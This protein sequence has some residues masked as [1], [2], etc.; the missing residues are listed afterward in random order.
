MILFVDQ[1]SGIL[2]LSAA[3]VAAFGEF[4]RKNSLITRTLELIS[5]VA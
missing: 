4:I 2:F 1:N 5:R 3:T